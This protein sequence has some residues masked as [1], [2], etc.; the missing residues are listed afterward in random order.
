[1]DFLFLSVCFGALP[2][3]RQQQQQNINRKTSDLIPL[4]HP[5]PLNQINVDIRWA[6]VDD[7]DMA[8][9]TD[10]RST[11]MIRCECR[12]THQTGVEMEAL[13]GATVAALTIYDMTKAISHQIEIVNTR[14][15]YKSGGKKIVG[16]YPTH[17]SSS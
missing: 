13:M 17:F 12:V 9:G 2:L 14:L 7:H 10:Y 6:T 1:M 5:M 16:T 15:L 8:I 3:S 4:C 11:V